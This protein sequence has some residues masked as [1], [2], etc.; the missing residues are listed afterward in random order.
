MVNQWLTE[1]GSLMPK[2]GTMLFHTPMSRR[3]LL[4]GTAAG[5]AAL[6]LGLR[7]SFAQDFPANNIDVTIP[8]GEGGGADRDSRAFVKVW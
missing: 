7:P 2:G 4:T 3:R 1:K 8:T 6:S 5:A